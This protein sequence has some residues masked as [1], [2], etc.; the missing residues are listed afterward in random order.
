MTEQQNST[1]NGIP[2]LR[3][4]DI[5]KKF[6]SVQALDKVSLE[7]GSG[8]LV[9]LV[10]DNGAGKSTLVK[11]IAGVYQPD[12]GTIYINDEPVVM[13]TPHQAREMGIETAY[14]DLAL[15][16]HLRVDGNLF[17]GREILTG[18]FIGR[19]LRI[20]DRRGMKQITR[21]NMK[22]LNIK[23]PGLD[24]EP[25]RRMSG[26]Q[27]QAV[28]LARS[29]FWGSKLLLLDEPTAALGASQRREAEKLI[30]QIKEQ[31]IPI[32]LISHN[33]EHVF[34]ICNRIAVL[35]HGRK[36]KDCKK[37]ETNPTEI[38]GYIT[39]GV[40]AAQVSRTATS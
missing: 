23:I 20:L 5:S 34:A 38:V 3:V 28:A 2:F 36:V 24:S 18:G 19:L 31:G 1:G 33:L 12:G 21:E 35:R 22:K 32:I 26:G 25:V 29:V 4:E 10:G 16:D 40:A 11:V 39:G 7:V 37:E 13:A 30:L 8:D 14:Q 17:L 27:R 9:G 15:V 6:Q